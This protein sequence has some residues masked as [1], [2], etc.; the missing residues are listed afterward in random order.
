M[1]PSD[2]PGGDPRARPGHGHP[3]APG[4]P[5]RAGCEL[6]TDAGRGATQHPGPGAC[7]GPWY[8]S[9]IPFGAGMLAPG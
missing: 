4:V 5:M 2:T 3:P 7:P 1:P 9:W 6:T 8:P